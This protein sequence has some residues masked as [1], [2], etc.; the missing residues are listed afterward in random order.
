MVTLA[1]PFTMTPEEGT[2]AFARAVTSGATHL[3]HSTGDLTARIKQ[4]VYLESLEGGAADRQNEAYGPAPVPADYERVLTEIWRQ[5][6]GLEQVGLTD[7]FFDLGGNSLTAL[8]LISRIRKTLQVQL[9][10]VAIFEAPT[11]SAMAQYLRPTNDEAGA[12]L[13]PAL[14]A[15][16]AQRRLQARQSTQCSDIAIIGMAGRFPGAG[17]IEQYWQNLR[18]GVESLTFFSDRALTRS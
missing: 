14:L 15:Q 13:A 3:V 1:R 16:L 5:T 2:D 4:W 6:L 18:D 12:G 7:N 17:T 11:I 10:A 8:Q 9:P